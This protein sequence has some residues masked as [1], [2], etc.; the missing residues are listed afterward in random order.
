[1][2]DPTTNKR[3]RGFFVTGTGTGVG[4]TIVATALART[5]VEEGYRVG[6]YKPALSG[7]FS[8]GMV[9]DP[10]DEF[11]NA[12]DDVRLWHAAGCPAALSQVSPQRFLAPLAPHLAARAEGKEIDPQLLRTG[13]LPWLANSDV[14]LVESAGGLFS[15][16]SDDETNADLA[17]EFGFP[18]VLVSPNALGVI[19]STIA[20]QFAA[21][22]Y[23]CGLQLAVIVLNELPSAQSDPSRSTNHEELVRRCAPCPVVRLAMNADRA[24]D[25]LRLLL[26]ATD[27][28]KKP[29]RRL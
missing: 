29:D 7:C 24:P 23:R 8:A 15:P 17:M 1:M 20:T 10:L 22:S 5:L 28:G 26:A 16:V 27:W 11:E 6:V 12:D 13:I 21:Q 14:T 19:H 4:K 9:I 2:N 3:A 25:L 18:I